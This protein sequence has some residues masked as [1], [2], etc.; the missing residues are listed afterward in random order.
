MLSIMGA[1]HAQAAQARAAG[2]QP[3]RFTALVGPDEPTAGDAAWALLSA[4]V[5]PDRG[6]AGAPSLPDRVRFA[7]RC[8]H[9]LDS[10]SPL[11]RVLAIAPLVEPWSEAAVCALRANVSPYGQNQFND[12]AP[13]RCHACRAIADGN[14]LRGARI[15][16][17]SVCRVT[18]YCSDECSA[19][20]WEAHKSLCNVMAEKVQQGA[21]EP[22][23][24]RPMTFVISR[25]GGQGDTSAADGS[26][27]GVW[28]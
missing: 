17:C 22:V 16:R 5:R 20:D 1:D 23:R 27:R 7:A 25:G 24:R 12:D 6:S 10:L 9:L 4:I 15:R 11:L 18:R 8:A 3:D 28:R 2:E 19:A 21:R 14:D 13:Q 26:F